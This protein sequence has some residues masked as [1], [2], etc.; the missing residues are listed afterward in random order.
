MCAS[1]CMCMCV[2]CVHTRVSARR[3]H[4]WAPVAL[5]HEADSRRRAQRVLW[6]VWVSDRGGAS[7]E[8]EL[9]GA[10]GRASEEGWAREGDSTPLPAG[11]CVVAHLSQLALPTFSHTQRPGLPWGSDSTSPRTKGEGGRGAWPPGRAP[12]W[13]P[14][15]PLR[16]PHRW[17][18]ARGCRPLSGPWD[19]VSRPGSLR[20]PACTARPGFQ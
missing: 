19:H 16:S 17:L 11:N 5:L 6:D 8:G 7:L 13:S 4:T 12:V 18:F 3:L 2:F 10:Q 14:V 15:P 20:C 1:I 9:W